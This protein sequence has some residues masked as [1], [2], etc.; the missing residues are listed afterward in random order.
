MVMVQEHSP[1]CV[2]FKKNVLK[3]YPRFSGKQTLESL[4]IKVADLQVWTSLKRDSSTG[5]LL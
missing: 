1:K 3:I 2:F 5:G 4:F